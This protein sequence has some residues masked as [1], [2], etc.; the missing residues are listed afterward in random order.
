MIIQIRHCR[1]CNTDINNINNENRQ[2]KY[3]FC[4]NCE[5]SGWR[6]CINCWKMIIKDNAPQW[7]I[8]CLYCNKKP[9]FFIS[10]MN[11]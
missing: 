6:R 4:D 7:I 3:I 9:G 1:I 11:L 10:L 2:Y 5:H 8:K